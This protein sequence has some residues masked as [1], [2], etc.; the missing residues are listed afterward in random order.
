VFDYV[1]FL[2]L[3]ERAQ[4]PDKYFIR[5]NTAPYTLDSVVLMAIGFRDI[6]MCGKAVK[7]YLLGRG[8]LVGNGSAC[9]SESENPVLLG[10]LAST[11]IIPVV[12][13][14]FIRLS[15]ISNNSGDIKKLAAEFNALTIG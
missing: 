6:I 10:S 7:N 4:F 9:N 12:K 5:I 8:I 3:K 1:E 13:K 11:G 2:Q 15:F 14:G